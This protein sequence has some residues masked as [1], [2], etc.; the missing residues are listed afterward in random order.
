MYV[1]KYIVPLIMCSMYLHRKISSQLHVRIYRMYK[2]VHLMFHYPIR[3][4]FSLEHLS[5][6]VR[7][8]CSSFD[9][10]DRPFLYEMAHKLMIKGLEGVIKGPPT[11]FLH[12]SSSLP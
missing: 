3:Q 5:L 6:E 10:F 12:L 9:F 4:G 1:Q 11:W 7:R 8:V 2:P